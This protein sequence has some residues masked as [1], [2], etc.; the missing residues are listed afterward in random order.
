[1]DHSLQP[2][3]VCG[4]GD[5][6]YLTTRTLPVDL[7]I[8]LGKILAVPVYH[9][10]SENCNAYTVPD[11]VLRILERL[12]DDM[13]EKKVLERTFSWGHSLKSASSFDLPKEEQQLL[14]LQAFTLSFTGQE[15]EDAI[16]MDVI[17]AHAVFFQSKHD[18][19]EYYLLKYEETLSEKETIFSFSK[20][21]DDDAAFS[22]AQYLRWDAAEESYLKELAILP[23]A[24]IHDLLTEEFGPLS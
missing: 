6:G 11:P 18:L 3:D 5:T 17:P 22:I 1:M 2:I 24:E 15:Y 10:R 23:L 8:G 19:T 4:C 12:A 21:Y 16:V 9:C 13:E 7:A 14:I 20:F